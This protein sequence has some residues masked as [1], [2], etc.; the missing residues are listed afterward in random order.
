M[1]PG[2]MLDRR[3]PRGMADAA[4]DRRTPVR[5]LASTSWTV[6]ASPCRRRRRASCSS[7]APAWRAAS[8]TGPE[9]TRRAVR[10]AIRSRRTRT[11]GYART[12]DLGRWL[13][14]GT[15][16]FL[17]RNDFQVKIRG[18]RIELGEIEARLRA[19]DGVS[20]RGGDGARGYA[21]EKRLVAYYTSRTR[22]LAIDAETIRRQL[23]AALPEYMVPSAYVRLE[24]LPLTPNGKLDRKALP[25]PGSRRLRGARV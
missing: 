20:E 12:G 2:R 6:G 21:G 25:A 4:S 24:S 17:G 16:E 13:P 7:A 15:I 5:T 18:F 19:C 3:G 1:W 10:L 8:G 22:A 11:R 23:A 9:L 14:D